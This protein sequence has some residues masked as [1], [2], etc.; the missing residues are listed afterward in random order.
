THTIRHAAAGLSLLVA[1]IAVLPRGADAQVPP[2]GAPAQPPWVQI[3]ALQPGPTNTIVDVPGILVGQYS[4][5]G[6]GYRSGTTVITT[7]S[8]RQ[9]TARGMTAGY[10]QM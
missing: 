6:D 3:T 1:G 4:R 8:T 10:S 9:V 7:D 5:F 2:A